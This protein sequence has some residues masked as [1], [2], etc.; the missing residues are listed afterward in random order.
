[1]KVYDYLL[2]EKEEMPKW[3]KTFNKGDKIDAEKAIYDSR[4]VFY[5][6]SYVDGQGVRTFNKCQYS[7]VFLYVDYLPSK[8][9]TYKS[10]TQDGAFKG[11]KL[12]DIQE[13]RE[14]DFHIGS[15]APHVHP[16]DEEMEFQKRFAKNKPYCFAAIYERKDEY[17][18]DFGSKR[19]CLI[20]LYADGIAT[21]DALFANKHHAPTAFILQ[22]HGFGGNYN[23]F[24]KGGYLH[25]I[26]VMTNTFPKY[27]MCVDDYPMWDGYHRIDGL[28]PEIGGM[29]RNLRYLYKQ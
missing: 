1:M 3:L 18:E 5:P 7:H 20:Y 15:W 6:G 16:T 21:Y 9:E 4:L 19:F 14:K 29:H 28:E 27:I 26:A 25:Q 10:L 11:Y 23:R 22:E 24:G 13:I 8:N 17:G 2:N 12:L